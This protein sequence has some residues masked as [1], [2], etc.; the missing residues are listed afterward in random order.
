LARL[1]GT[2]TS[3][4]GE[5]NDTL[6]AGDGT[7][8][9]YGGLGD[10]T[11]LDGL[12]EDTAIAG[13][14]EDTFPGG[15]GEDT[16]VAGGG[17]D[18]INDN[19]DQYAGY[20][21]DEEGNY[22][23]DQGVLVAYANGEPPV[24][25]SVDNSGDGTQLAE[26]NGSNLY[27]DDNG[28]VWDLDTGNWVSGPEGDTQVA[29]NAD[30]TGDNTGDTTDYSGDTTDY[31]SNEDT[32]ED[33][34]VKDGGFIDLLYKKGGPVHMVN[35]G[36]IN[37]SGMFIPNGATDNG[38][39]T[40]TD[41]MGDVY[42]G[43]GSLISSSFDQGT[44]GYDNSAT[45]SYSP[46]NAPYGSYDP[47][48]GTGW[49]NTT[50]GANRA[51]RR[52][53]RSGATQGSMAGKAQDT[54]IYPNALSSTGYSD[55]NGNE[56]ADPNATDTASYGNYAASTDIYPDE[57]SPTG[58]SDINGNMV[59]ET[60]QL[61]SYDDSGQLLDSNGNVIGNANDY[62]TT[63][64][65]NDTYN[66]IFKAGDIYPDEGSPTGYSDIN[67]NMVDQTGQPVSYDD[68]GNLVDAAGE[69]V[70]NAND[71]QTTSDQNDTYSPYTDNGDGT[72]TATDGTVYDS[73]NNVVSQG[74][75]TT[76]G[77]Q[78]TQ[79]NNGI[80]SSI[81][82]A[83]SGVN[84][85]DLISG[86]MGA[87]I[88]NL[89]SN[90][91]GGGNTNQGVDMNQL[92]QNQNYG[93]NPL[94]AGSARN[95]GTAG[96]GMSNMYV[97]YEQYAYWNPQNQQQLYSDLGVSGYDQQPEDQYG[98]QYG[99]QTPEDQTQDQTN[100]D[101]Q[102]NWQDY[103]NQTQEEQQSEEPAPEE[104]TP[105]SQYASGGSTHYTFGKIITPQDNLGMK[106]GGLSQAHTMH[107]HMTNPIKRGRID[108]SQGSSVNGAGDGQSDDIPAMLADGEYV[109]DADTVAQLGNGSN[110]AGAKALDK[111]R[112]AIRAHKRA[113]PI[114]KI[115]PKAKSP[116]AYLKESLNG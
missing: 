26:D 60:G 13:S 21:Q 72:W 51:A 64:D 32:G 41:L 109:I 84:G 42:D 80:L 39:G 69:V 25:D 93:G 20:F 19:S 17:E 56:V 57:G 111:M 23:D 91:G 47:G 14:G 45:R 67:G 43:N 11:T 54:A 78:T 28:D 86:G 76:Q 2:D 63:S 97:P 115:P 75:P 55:I 89:L 112:E 102:N 37:R 99:E 16:T 29:D 61:V 8:T 101:D 77:N 22:Y 24:D 114:N 96:T 12:G 53:A 104:P 106:R 110:K 79:N 85:S 70:S 83:L 35:G 18:V 88:A 71:Y 34:T 66:T 100:P 15:L 7:D 38:D 73:N 10:D 31:A 98:D 49:D 3:I 65:Q 90:N 48:T 59:D 107:S 27:T 33:I 1:G 81:K 44:G 50:V 9:L 82:D 116:L 103:L 95:S 87:L 30:Y 113:A 52:A 68:S 5:G 105:E 74:D 62:Q 108:F 6:L 94:V 46:K 58:Y 40:Y 36:T 92:A 4:G